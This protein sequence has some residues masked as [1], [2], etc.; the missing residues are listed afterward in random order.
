MTKHFETCVRE[1]HTTFECP[2]YEHPDKAPF[3]IHKLRARLIEEEVKE[4]Y[5]AT[6]KEDVLDAL[7]D[8]IYVVVGTA[9]TYS[10][11]ITERGLLP[12]MGLPP[13]SLAA[14]SRLITNDL[15]SMFPC[16]KNLTEA[17]DR[18]LVCV[19]DIASIKGFKLVEAFDAVHANN[20]LK[21]WDEPTFHGAC[22]TQ[23]SIL[24]VKPKGDKFLVRDPGGKVIKPPGHTKVN[25]TP[26]I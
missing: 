5:T 25:L 6:S 22:L 10:T 8:T 20:M 19:I 21:L 11:P 23:Q 3:D 24:N 17:I 9:I 15:H 1:F 2:T 4:Y 13:P 18:T 26:F 7:C 16:Q 12:L 14:N